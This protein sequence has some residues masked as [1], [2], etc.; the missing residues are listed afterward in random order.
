MKL[1]EFQQVNELDLAHVVG[2]Y[3]AAG[4]KQIGNR[5]MGRPEGQ[6]SVKDNMASEKFIR[7]FVGRAKTDLNSAI[8]SGLVNQNATGATPTTAPTPTANT[9]PNYSSGQQTVAPSSI[10]Y[11]I[12]PTTATKP[13]TTTTPTKSAPLTPAQT[14]QQKLST[15]A[16][17]AQKQMSANPV[18]TKATTT[19][20]A[21]P[22]PEEIRKAKQSAAA[23]FAQKQM[24]PYSKLPANQTAI[25]SANIRQQKQT[26][27]AQ[28]ANQQA[29]PFSKFTPAPAVWKNNRNP[30]APAKRS[31][32]LE[33]T[34]DKLNTVFEAIVDP[35][36]ATQKMTIAQYVKRMFTKYLR[37]QH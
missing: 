36:Q 23:A 33:S 21:T 37:C 5:I 24:V 9:T 10:S 27:A 28:N 14:R 17:V 26:A 22:S 3:G 25:Q 2:D 12:K 34:F 29:V 16:N 15:A 11:N 13:T 4:L 1:N 32:T 18:V 7:D 6:L 31:P 20:P 19:P 8:Q 35:Q 30:S